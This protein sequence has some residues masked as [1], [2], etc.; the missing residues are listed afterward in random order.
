MIFLDFFIYHILQFSALIWRI[1]IFYANFHS[2][3]TFRD[4]DFRAFH[5]LNF[6]VKVD[7]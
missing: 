4:F 5:N 1:K 7:C 2:Q 6:D 3:Q